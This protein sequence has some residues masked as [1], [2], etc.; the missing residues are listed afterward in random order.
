MQLWE[1]AV[2]DGVTTGY[3]GKGVFYAWAAGNGHLKTTIAP[4]WTSIATASTPSR[5]SAPS[6]HD[7]ITQRLF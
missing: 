4:T 7:D 1:T 2:K 3:G 6:G 5:R